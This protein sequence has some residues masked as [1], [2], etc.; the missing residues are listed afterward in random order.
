[1]PRKKTKGRGN[2]LAAPRG[3]SYVRGF[4]QIPEVFT[5][6]LESFFRGEDFS[7]LEELAILLLDRPTAIAR[8]RET[9]ARLRT[10]RL[11]WR[12]EAQ[13]LKRARE[14]TNWTGYPVAQRQRDL[15]FIAL[16]AEGARSR[17]GAPDFA[18]GR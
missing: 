11:F 1:M 14:R 15:L 2:A 5:D 4:R 17:V 18:L 16:K 10:V 13:A 3:S 8:R 7:A 6:R 9:Q 12:H